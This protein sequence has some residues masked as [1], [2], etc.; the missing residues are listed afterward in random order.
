MFSC[1]ATTGLVIT[2]L[3]HCSVSTIDTKARTR[4]PGRIVADKEQ[5]R[6]GYVLDVSYPLE[7]M[8]RSQGLTANA[9]LQHILCHYR[10]DKAGVNRVDV[11]ILPK[12]PS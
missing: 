3:S 8:P 1:P 2:F 5:H 6:L 9:I 11:N 4:D 12:G 10:L 7:R